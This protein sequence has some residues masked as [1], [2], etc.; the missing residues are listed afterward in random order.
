MALKR[1]LAVSYVF[2]PVGGAGV[3]RLTKFVKYLPEFGWQ[4]T[5]LTAARPSVPVFDASLIDDIPQTT[6]VVKARTLEPAYAVKRWV[7]T[8]R[9]KGQ[10]STQDQRAVP[11]G[12]TSTRFSNRLRSAVES[13]FRDAANLVLQ[14]DP[15][16]LWRRNAVKAGLE[17]LRGERYDVILASA[18]PFS[19]FL[20][21]QELGRRTGLPLVLDYRDEWTT[22]QTHEEN[23]PRDAYS[24]WRQ[25]RMQRS[26]IRA[27]SALITT[28]ARSAA[29]LS[30]TASAVEAGPHVRHIYNGFDAADI[31]ST[32]NRSAA[33]APDRETYKVAYV[34]T[35]WNLTSIAPVVNA[36]Q[37][38]CRR[39]PDVGA[40]LELL[41]AGR[42]TTSQ[43]QYLDRLQDL[44]C[45]VTRLD[46]VDHREALRLMH[47]ADALLLVLS[48][49]LEAERVV[50]AKVFEYLAMRKP[51]YGI[52]PDGEVAQLLKACPI[53]CV[54]SPR[55]VSGLADRLTSD[56]ERH[57]R[58]E[59][60]SL[61]SWD[62]Q[63][64]ERRSLTGQLAELL[65]QVT[66]EHRRR[67][68]RQPALP[69][70]P[71]HLNLAASGIN[72]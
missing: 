17:I 54:H 26:A 67:V 71:P 1:V 41:F 22:S 7:A 21:A 39:F 50:P 68:T 51:I 57:R 46:Y 19:T 10:P 44:P 70:T 62:P 24:V 9:G 40:R 38:L 29:F 23:R 56:I 18:P 58:G 55:D 8:T 13:T 34:G 27:A 66:S 64:F 14:P 59:I 16:I 2:P 30:Q 35:L 69:V 5:V 36:V 4:S 6:R 28:T 43:D 37:E 60:R 20:V 33:S 72:E 15:Q 49:V 47:S 65:D 48:D 25:Q 32:V 45:R 3:Q 42:R 61:H 11:A 53:A 52:V 63:P 31:E 12:A